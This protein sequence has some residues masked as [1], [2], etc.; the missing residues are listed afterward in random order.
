VRGLAEGLQA[1]CGHQRA[2]VGA[3]Q[4]VSRAA[5]PDTRFRS[6]SNK[7]QLPWQPQ[8]LFF[9]RTLDSSVTL[10]NPPNITKAD[11][12]ALWQLEIWDQNLFDLEK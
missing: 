6:H 1:T 9:F 8:G 2:A 7:S 12:S 3:S 4:S 10:E 11:F 5:W